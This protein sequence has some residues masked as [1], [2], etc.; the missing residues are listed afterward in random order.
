M[1]NFSDNE[2]LRK[3]GKEYLNAS[4]CK[5]VVYSLQQSETFN[6]SHVFL[7][8]TIAELSTL[9]QVRFFFWP[10]LYSKCYNPFLL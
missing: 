3:L 1:P 7:S 10:T 4:L 2:D 6:I 9:K 5:F 8:L